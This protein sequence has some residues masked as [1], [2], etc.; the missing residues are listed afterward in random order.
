LADVVLINRREIAKVSERE[1][2]FTKVIGNLGRKLKQ[3][4]QEGQL[5][6]SK[7]ML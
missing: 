7:R 2:E 5:R 6:H 3:F 1:K 4:A